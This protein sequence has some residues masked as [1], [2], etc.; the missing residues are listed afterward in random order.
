MDGK[1]E[2]KIRIRRACILRQ[3]HHVNWDWLYNVV[4]VIVWLSFWSKLFSLFCHVDMKPHTLHPGR[5]SS[6][7]AVYLLYSLW[8]IQRLAHIH[9]LCNLFVLPPFYLSQCP[10]ISVS[11]CFYL[12]FFI[13]PFMQCFFKTLS[14]CRRVSNASE[15]LCVWGLLHIAF[16]TE[17]KESWESEASLFFH[18]RDRAFSKLPLR[19]TD[20]EIMREG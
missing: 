1:L 17:S 8:Y 18:G 3:S 14:E 7:S 4:D 5:D 10:I 6:P 16:H 19:Q 11:L 13:F 12:S 20:R 15:C 2:E 9:L